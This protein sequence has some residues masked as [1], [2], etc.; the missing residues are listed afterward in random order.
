MLGKEYPSTLASINS[1]ANV[2]RDQ[3]KHK[4][5]EEVHRQALG[6]SKT[7]LGKEHP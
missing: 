2:P 3:G 5:A 4:Q 1:L 6:L 7:V